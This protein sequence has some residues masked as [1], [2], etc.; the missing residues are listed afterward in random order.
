MAWAWGEAA[1]LGL[2]VTVGGGL[3]AGA[4]WRKLGGFFLHGADVLVNFG[5]AADVLGLFGKG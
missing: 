2:N 3:E 4:F 5:D 1:F